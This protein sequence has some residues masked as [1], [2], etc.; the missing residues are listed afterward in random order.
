MITAIKNFK[1]K[2]LR[3]YT[4]ICAVLIAVLTIL[5]ASSVASPIY[6]IF[7]SDG[8]DNDPQYFLYI[9]KLILRGQKP[10]IDIY[11]HKGLYIFLYYVLANM[12]GGKI[13]LFILEILIYSFFYYFFILTLREMF[14]NNAKTAQICT[15]FFFIIFTFM[16]QGGSDVDPQFPLIALLMYFYFKGI[17]NKDFKS[18]MFGNIVAGLLAGMDINI[19]M[20]D[21]IVPFSAVVFYGYFAIKNKKYTYI[22][23][24]A[25]LCLAG[26]AVMCGIPLIVAYSGGYLKEMI[27]SMSSSNAGYILSKRFLFNPAQTSCYIMLLV[28]LPLLIISLIQLK[29]KIDKDEWVFYLISSIICYPFELLIC[30]FPHYFLPMIPYLIIYFARWIKEFNFVKNN[31]KTENIFL[32]VSLATSVIA[33]AIYPMFYYLSPIYKKDT[34]MNQYIEKVC[35]KDNSDIYALD[36]GVS[37]YLNGNFTVKHKYFSSQ[38]W[39]LSY[40]KDVISEIEA[41]LKSG[42]VKYLITGDYSILRAEN[43]ATVDTLLKD[44]DNLELVVDTHEGNKYIDIYRLN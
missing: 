4:L 40:E 33:M 28:A 32:Y 2:H 24:D 25:L 43:K 20:S 35:G 10:Y 11:D 27:S 34:V 38:T 16:L 31:N 6:T 13:G 30:L 19:R 17:K 7:R 37:F 3:I 23:R 21:A 26:V 1:I 14:D 18:F 44:L 15:L 5:F 41:Y 8:F 29:K 42:Q 39:H 9:G 36:Y 12:M 22:V